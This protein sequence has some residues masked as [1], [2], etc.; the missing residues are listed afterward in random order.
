MKDYLFLIGLYLIVSAG[1]GALVDID[2]LVFNP[3]RNYK[4]WTKINWFGIGIITIFLNIF[5]LPYAIGY[6]IY[7]IFTIGRNSK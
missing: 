2:L 7:I 4:T 5:F 1:L 3:L 6:W